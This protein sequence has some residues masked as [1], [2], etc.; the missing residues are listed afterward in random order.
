[1]E[2]DGAG[3]HKGKNEVRD[4]MQ[5]VPEGTISRI[6]YK[7][8][9]KSRERKDYMTAN[10]AKFNHKRDKSTGSQGSQRAKKAKK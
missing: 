5:F 9:S 10:L 1:M 8:A 6:G 3:G 4:T 2:N 7:R